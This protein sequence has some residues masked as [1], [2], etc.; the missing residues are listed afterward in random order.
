M[1]NRRKRV[2]VG[3]DTSTANSGFAIYKRHLMNELVNSNLFDVGEVGYGGTL[4]DRERVNWAYY[5]TAVHHEDPRFNEYKN[6]PAN[7]YGVWRWENIAMDFKVTTMFCADDPWQF[8]HT[9][10]SPL[11]PYYTVVASPTIDS[12]P[13]RQD[14]LQIF[15]KVDHLYAYTEWGCNYLRENGLNCIDS[16]GM[17]IDPNVMKPLDKKVLRQKYRLP[18]DAI[19]F[20]FVARN[21]LRKRFPELID[22]FARYLKKAPPE[23]AAKSYLLLHT[24]SPDAGWNLATHL[25]EHNVINKVLFTYMC[26]K[27]GEIFITTYKDD[28]TYSPF[29]G[30]MTAFLPNVVYSP[31]DTVLAEIYNLMDCYVQCSNCEGFGNP[32][33]EAAACNIYTMGTDYS[34]TGELTKKFGGMPVPILLNFDHNVMAYRGCIDPEIW[35]E[36]LLKYALERPAVNSRDLVLQ[37][38]TWTHIIDKVIKAIDEADHPKLPWNAPIKQYGLPPLKGDMTAT[39]FIH[40]LSSHIPH[41]KWSGFNLMNLRT[42][43]TQIDLRGK[44][45]LAISPEIIAQRYKEVIERINKWERLRCGVDPI[46]KEDYMYS[47]Y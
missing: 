40:L 20:G 3:G 24:S 30:D 23:I 16:I 28:R 44:Q 47:N 7:E 33:L 42:L 13:Q 18:E 45:L 10:M 19:I 26:R 31:P 36:A 9:L 46:Q 15:A 38:Y 41:L 39:Q 21:Q 14:F 22:G 4:I 1:I 37:K 43:N 32:N 2:L 5:P 8:S 11:K 17:G 6:N 34:G 12:L 29:S 35:S 25:L 27:T